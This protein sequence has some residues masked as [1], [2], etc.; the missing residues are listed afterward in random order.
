MNENDEETVIWESSGDI[1]IDNINDDNLAIQAYRGIQNVSYNALPQDC[2][3]LFKKSNNQLFNLCSEILG[4]TLKISQLPEPE[5]VDDFRY[6]LLEAIERMKMLASEVN[7]P[8]AVIDKTCCIFAIVLD[9]LVHY[10]SWGENVAWGNKTLLSELFGM[11]K[12]GGELFFLITDKA[13]RQPQRLIDFIELVYLFLNIGFK[14]QYRFSNKEQ[15]RHYSN[16]LLLTLEKYR[17]H[18]NILCEFNPSVVDVRHPS[19]RSWFGIITLSSIVLILLS[20]GFM[21][22]LYDT[23]IDKRAFDWDALPEYTKEHTLKPNKVNTSYSSTDEDFIEEEFI[24]ENNNNRTK[25]NDGDNLNW[26]VDLNK[27]ARRKDAY[28]FLRKLPLSQYKPF[29][30]HAN[31]QFYIKIKANTLSEAKNIQ[32]WYVNNAN[33]AGQILKLYGSQRESNRDR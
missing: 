19:K 21:A 25:T 4:I 17:T 11:K 12:N 1:P 24:T 23:T 6:S 2:T 31:N 7:Y 29:V 15:L 26:V 33:V 28:L 14:G 32:Q 13:L 8:V 9:E 18:N 27:F 30:A 16:Q 10:S 5:E 22:L 20:F 3:W